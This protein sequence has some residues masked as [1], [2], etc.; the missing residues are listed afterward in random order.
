MAYSASYAVDVKAPQAKVFDYVA[1]VSRHGEWGSADDHMKAA[2]EKPG[3]PTMGS[4]YSADGLLNGKPNHS[5]VTITA[6]DAPKRLAF[7]AE[8]SNSVFHHEF[9]FSPSNGGT[10]VERHVTMTKGPFYFPLVLSIFK[11]T[12]QKNYNGAMTNLKTKVES[13]A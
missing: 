6:I 11:S 10:H 8:D 2:A 7:D 5:V 3:P 9:T 13:G 12:V 1:D 4:R